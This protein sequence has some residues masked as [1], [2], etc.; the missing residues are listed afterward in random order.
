[1]AI[2]LIARAVRHG[3][4]QRRACEVIGI[5]ERSLQ[6][7]RIAGLTDRRQTVKKEPVNS[8]SRQEKDEILAVCNSEEFRNQPPKQIVPALADRGVFLA[9]ESS[10][11]RILHRANQLHHRGRSAKPVVKQ[12]PRAY[13]ADGPNQVWSWDITYLASNIRG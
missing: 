6:N 10:F 12:R 11:Y 4:R 7:W 9:S 2:T 3:A 8:L 1:M 5:T 13:L